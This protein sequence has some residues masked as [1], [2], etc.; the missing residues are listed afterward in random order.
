MT[1][2]N[3]LFGTRRAS[4]FTLIELLVVIVI[5]ALLISIL[6]P[7]LREARLTAR[8]LRESATCRSQL[9]VWHNYATTYKDGLMIPGVPWTWAH[10]NTPSNYYSSPPDMIN[11]N[12]LS[13]V[14]SNPTPDTGTTLASDVVNAPAPAPAPAAAPGNSVFIEG[15]CIK[16]WPLRFWGWAEFPGYEMQADKATYLAF[17]NRSW[18]PSNTQQLYGETINTYDG[19][20]TF[21]GAMAYHPTFA[22][23]SI[24]V[25]GHYRWGA[26]TSASA[27]VLG[28]TPNKHFVKR[29]SEFN[30]PDG[31]MVLTDARSVDLNTSSMGAAD[32]G[33]AGIAWTTTAPIVPGFHMVTPPKIGNLYTGSGGG[34][35]PRNWVVS[36]QFKE[37]TNPSDWGYV[38]PKWKGRS[39]TG[40]ADGHVST[41]TLGEMRDM[42]MWTDRAKDPNWIPTLN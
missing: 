25:G 40:F 23:N 20:T 18:A 41:K 11:G 30:R 29:L 32:Y 38:Y 16:V 14:M 15:S 6:L 36:D 10:P 2:G 3:R 13:L 35:A 21:G 26:Y 42:R 39:V 12:G 31:I 19:P 37:V 33:G 34:N 7:A 27:T 17:R 8:M 28:N 4:A 1:Q 9:Q 22:M 5:I 24:F